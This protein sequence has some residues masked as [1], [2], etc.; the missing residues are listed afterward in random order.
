MYLI[1]SYEKYPAI[2]AHTSGNSFGIGNL[3][4]SM[5]FSIFSFGFPFKT[6]FLFPS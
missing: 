2:I 6:F 5:I 1:A 3:N 4:F